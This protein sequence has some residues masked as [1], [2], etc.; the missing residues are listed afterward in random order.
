MSYF[1]F[2]VSRLTTFV[3]Y[4]CS[5]GAMVLFTATLHLNIWIIFGT[6]FLLG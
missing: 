2:D 1:K 4:A 6:S 3:I 5:F